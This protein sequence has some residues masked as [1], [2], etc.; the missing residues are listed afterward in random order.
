MEQTQNLPGRRGEERKSA[1]ARGMV[2][3]RKLFAVLSSA[4]AGGVI[5]VSAPAGSGKTVLVR[6][7]VRDAGLRDRVAWIS[8]ERGERDGQRF[9]LSVIGALAG[10]AGEGVVARVSPAPGFRGRAMVERL[11]ADLRSLEE[12]AVLVIDDLHELG[13]AEA[14]TWLE[15]FLAR[16][17]P[18]LRVVLATREDPRLGLHRLRL[19]GELTE[20]RGPDLL[21][22][23]GET[24][25][26]LD[27]AGVVL[28]DAGLALLQERTEGWAAGVR[29]A[30]ISLAGHPEPE[31]FVREFSGSE[32][33]VA[34]YL[35]AEVLDRQPTEVRD[36]LL[37]T[38][39]LERVSGP[40][41]DFLTGGLGSEAILQE[42]EEANSFVTSVDV[43]R[44]WFRYHHLFADLLQ[45][46]LRRVAPASIGSL[47]QAAARWFEQH[48]YVVEAVRHAQA[49]RDW[50]G[51]ACLL[52]DNIP[53][54]ILDG[55]GA[56]VHAL[57]A[58]FPP[59]AASADAE[60]AFAFAVAGLFDG[61]L[62]EG[63]EYIDAAERLAPAVP[64]ERG[65][66]FDLLLATARLWLARLRG[67][68]G[69]ALDGM[70]S[71]E[72]ALAAQSAC[73]LV[74]KNDLRAVAL[75]NLGIA[76]LWSF[77]LEDGRRDLEQA[78][79][80]A[81]RIGRPYL[82]AGCLAHLG[83][84]ATF[85][86]LPASMGLQLSEE[87]VAI[88]EA[89][90]WGDDPV[91]A[92]AFATSGTLLVWLGRFEET[93]RWL[94][95]AQ[96]ALRPEGEPA[97]EL[98][99]HHT[100]GLLRL[101]QG[102]LGQAMAAFRA[103]ERMQAL[104][105]GE[106]P[107]TIH[108]RIRLLQTQVRLG[109]AAAARAALAGIGEE[110]RDRAGMRITAAA[111]YLAEGCPEQVID[112]LA[113]VVEGS[114]KALHPL[115]PTIEALLYEAAARDQLGDPRAAEAS[116]EWALELAEPEG[117][118]LPFI[119]APVQ[120]L[121]ERHPRHRTA[122]ATLL[123]AILDVLAGTSPQPRGAAAPLLEELSDAELRVLRY[124]PGNLTA[125]EIAAEL[126]VS[127]NTTR[128]HL[129]H[130][131][132]KLDAH[133]RTEAVARA[134]QLGLLAPSLQR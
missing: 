23:D 48:G 39:V 118:I 65:R 109:Q 76:E 115:W 75:L 35:L 77:R 3:R 134:R 114:A 10:V 102:R 22:T 106:H 93:Q 30:V 67:D 92:A 83:V 15:L 17:P 26:L 40:L 131:Y 25:K 12:P 56:T 37:R 100:W 117:V 60:L 59:G 126:C 84:A 70:R 99:L 49:A 74:V 1:A 87:A 108:L 6:S 44:F 123:S 51:A 66:F 104:L 64:G 71:L 125:S 21:F 45:L 91:A 47:H 31:R 43:G 28:S 54:L 81:R 69:G 124:L 68:L 38:S 73:E 53:G 111:I 50:P 119:L 107:L 16:L 27:A 57:L 116:V 94:D 18:E 58:A 98:L 41:A 128:T 79:A 9:W 121:L 80:L 82:E 13:S 95:R 88:A 62:D 63:A 86:G 85:S 103:A 110:E 113:P 5:L 7:W 78:L 46:E 36:L 120:G 96:R 89:H 112:V 61:R 42:L 105:A 2:A 4:P 132:A 20:I 24:R 34:G 19:A 32:R 11:L 8:V 122:H 14:L 90:G 127:R 130:I 133:T 29:L 129:R 101:G 33:T 55:R 52:A 72:A 97:T